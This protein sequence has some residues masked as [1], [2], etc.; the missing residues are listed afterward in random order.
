MIPIVSDDGEIQFSF[1][2]DICNQ[3]VSVMVGYPEL[4]VHYLYID[5]VKKLKIYS[6]VIAKSSN[7]VVGNKVQI[8]V[9]GACR[10]KSKLYMIYLINKERRFCRFDMKTFDFED[11]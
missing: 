7:K 2:S 11:L 3:P 6:E 9:L 10:S 5:K 1:S 4:E 8:Q